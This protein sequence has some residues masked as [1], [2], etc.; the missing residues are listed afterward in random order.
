MSVTC[1]QSVIPFILQ[2]IYKLWCNICW[3][4]YISNIK[5]AKMPEKLKAQPYH[6]KINM[7]IIY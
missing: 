7:N 2:I 5:R 3:L 4:T 6:I 1:V